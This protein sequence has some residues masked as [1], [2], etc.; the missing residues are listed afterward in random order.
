MCQSRK[1]CP[2][3]LQRVEIQ[4]GGNGGNAVHRL[5]D[6]NSPGVDYHAPAIARHDAGGAAPHCPA[7][8]TQ[9]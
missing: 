9:H 4:L 5:G 3:R 7:A 1:S 2:D 8:A 6:D